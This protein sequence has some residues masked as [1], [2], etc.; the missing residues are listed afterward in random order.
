MEFLKP[1]SQ[2]SI[3][4][5]GKQ[6]QRAPIQRI[7]VQGIVRVEIHPRSAKFNCQIPI[8]YCQQNLLIPHPGAGAL[9]GGFFA[10]PAEAMLLQAAS[11]GEG[12]GHAGAGARQPVRHLERAAAQRRQVRALLGSGELLQSSN[13]FIRALSHSLLPSLRDRVKKYTKG[14]VGY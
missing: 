10:G 14:L 3:I 4:Y 1:G 12:H 7:T 11:G 9:T 5:P 8:P 2:E 13:H 6:L